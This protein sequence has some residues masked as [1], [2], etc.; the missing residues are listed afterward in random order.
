ME[1]EVVTMAAKEQVPPKFTFY[2]I[3]PQANKETSKVWL[4]GMPFQ[5]A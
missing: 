5:F 2:L 4:Q 3:P 1:E